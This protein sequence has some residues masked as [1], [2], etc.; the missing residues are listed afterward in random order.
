MQV[1]LSLECPFACGEL[2]FVQSTTSEKVFFHCVMCATAFKHPKEMKN[3]SNLNLSRTLADLS[4]EGVI[5]PT[6][7]AIDK[8]GFGTWVT[9]EISECDLYSVKEIYKD[10]YQ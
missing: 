10:V 2:M 4:P 9:E 1:Y 8:A 3:D 6:K 7:E 5:L